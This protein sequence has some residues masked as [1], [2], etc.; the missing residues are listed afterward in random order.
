MGFLESIQADLVDNDASISTT[1]RKLRLLAARLGSNELTDWIKY[2]AGGYPRQATIP[3]Y[4]VVPIFFSGTFHGAFGGGVKNAPIPPVFI[5]E[6]ASEDLLTYK[7]RESAAAVEK[8]AA[9]DNGLHLDYS[10][11]ILLLRGKVYPDHEPAA[12]RGFVSRPSLIETS[13]AIRNRLLE[14][15]IEIAN[16]IPNAEG[17]ELTSIKREPD[18]ARQIFHQTV[19]GN[20]TNIHSSGPDAR[21]HVNVIQHDQESLKNGLLESGLSAEESSELSRLISNQEP[22][23]DGLNLGVKHWLAE[24]LTKGIDTTLQGGISALT[25][26][27]QEATMQ[28]WGFK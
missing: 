20:M 15:T 21:I 11:L 1:L 10:N 27:V 23:K 14:I 26:V 12:I 17:V 19:H 3:D 18:V 9:Q 25:R 24:R 5:K 16:R 6:F 8:M 28:Y 4:R 7:I 13:N 22:G 2:E